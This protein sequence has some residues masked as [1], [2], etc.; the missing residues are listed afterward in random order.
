MENASGKFLIAVPGLED[1]NFKHTVVLICEHSGEGAFGIV[2]NRIFMNS[3][4]PLLKALELKRTVVDAPV[5]YGGPVKPEQ[6][7]IIYS[8]FDEKYGAIKIAE[9]LAV[10]AS[11]EIL[12]DIAEGRGP[13]RFLFSL[14]FSGWSSNQLDQELMTDS[15]LI[16][17]LDA[18]ILFNAPVADR[19][20]LAANSIGVD[21]ERYCG[22]TGWA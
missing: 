10:T 2:V 16:A 13:E 21:L 22:R 8:P 19:W 18:D 11:K 12:L 4:R 3:F 7:Y 9:E 15:W 14:G 17:P 5:Y 20:K 6:G 1:P